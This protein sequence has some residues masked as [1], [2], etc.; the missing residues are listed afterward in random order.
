MLDQVMAISF[1]H[2]SVKRVKEL[3]PKLTT[4]ILYTGQFVDTIGAARAALADSVRPA[5][6]YWTAELVAQV[7]AAGL[8]ASSW[9]VNDEA[10]MEYV[11]PMGL[12]SIGCNFP[13]RMRAFVDRVGR[14]RRS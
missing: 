1:H 3:E 5:W 6:S 12:D 4:G 14:G 10:L 9:T 13:D 8:G 11:V 2:G 7:H